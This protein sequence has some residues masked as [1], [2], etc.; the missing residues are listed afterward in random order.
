M[1]VFS[2]HKSLTALL[3]ENNIEDSSLEA[4]F[5]LQH[6]LGLSYS[7]YILHST[8]EVSQEH[9]NLAENM[10]NRRINGEPLQYIIGEWDF[11]G[12]TL[13][14]GKGVLIPRPETEILCEYVLENI[15]NIASPVVYD[16]CSGS[17]CIG[18]S[19]KNER[20]DAKVFLVEKSDEALVYLKENCKNI[21]GDNLPEIIQGDILRYDSFENLPFADVIISNPPYIRSDEIPSL[22]KEVLFEPEMALD[23]GEDG[24]IF[25]RVLVN[26]WSQK[27]KNTGFMAFECGEDQSDD[28]KSLFKAI[29]FD[30]ETINDYNNI[31]RIV[32]GRRKTD[33][34]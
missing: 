16:L 27:L 25:Y 11:M 24:L 12:M 23:G 13:R 22:Q 10:I 29:A 8:Y 17:G 6:I 9:V 26:E 33:V 30:S 4:R 2:L 3:D 7:N 31:Q 19:I 14:V 21:C 15:K 18:L 1:T 5:I 34:I 20:P 28:I 32:T